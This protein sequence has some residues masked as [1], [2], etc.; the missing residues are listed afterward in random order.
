MMKIVTLISLMVW[1]LPL[2]IWSQ[3]DE[4]I[5]RVDQKIQLAKEYSVQ[6]S[7][8]ADIPMV[9]ILPSKATIY[10]KQKDQLKIVAK[11]ISIF[12]KQGFTELPALLRNKKDFTVV[13]TGVEVINGVSCQVRT[14]LPSNDT[15]ELIIAKLWI[16]PVSALIL[17]SQFT[18]RSSGMV[19]ST[20]VYG[21]QKAM[22]LPDRIECTVDVKKF[23][24]PKGMATDINKSST[25]AKTNKP[26]KTGKITIILT[27]YVVNKGAGS[28]V[29]K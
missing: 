22:A 19:S 12:P 4:L 5:T 20:Y 29:F 25:S 1:L 26:G 11:G 15:S 21:T 3:N 17:K 24:I 7:I 6:A 2:S 23:K 9:K 28:K 10:F 8:D 14:F 16:D 13:S 27:N 18:T